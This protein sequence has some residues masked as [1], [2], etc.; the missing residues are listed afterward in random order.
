MVG[1][2]WEPH[3]GNRRERSFASNLHIKT[4][5]TFPV[6]RPIWQGLPNLAKARCAISNLGIKVSWITAIL[7][8]RWRFQKHADS[9]TQLSASWIKLI[10]V[11][12][13]KDCLDKYVLNTYIPLLSRHLIWDVTNMIAV[14]LQFK[15]IVST[16]AQRDSSGEKW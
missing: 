4:T 6:N 10:L 12:T 11:S 9:L 5:S 13:N 3:M 1:Y 7:I 8:Y 15:W 14:Q 2:G 16:L